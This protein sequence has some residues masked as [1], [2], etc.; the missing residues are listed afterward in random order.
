MFGRGRM[1]AGRG[2]IAMSMPPAGGRGY[3][4]SLAVLADSFQQFR[5][6][7][8]LKPAM[9]RAARMT[10]RPPCGNLLFGS[11]SLARRSAPE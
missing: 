3:R 2:A 9:S 8:R 11:R 5:K 4:R 1:L 7:I 10:G 6:K